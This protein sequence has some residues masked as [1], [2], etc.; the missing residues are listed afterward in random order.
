VWE[1]QDSGWDTSPRWDRGIVEAVDLNGWLHLDQLLLAR[2]ADILG[3]PSVAAAWRAKA[4]AT[5]AA[6]RTRLWDESSGV[7]WD[8]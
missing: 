2:M 6:F 3:Q 1:G 7:F 8:R 4:A 5:K